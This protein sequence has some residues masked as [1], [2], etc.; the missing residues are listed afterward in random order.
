MPPSHGGS[1]RFEPCTAHHNL[2]ERVNLSNRSITTFLPLAFLI[3]HLLGVFCGPALSAAPGAGAAPTVSGKGTLK[4]LY[5]GA[6]GGELEPCGCSPKTE[7]GGLARLAGYLSKHGAGPE[8]GPYILLDAG[9]AFDKDTPQ[10]RLK[11]GTLLRAFAQM[12]Y[13]AVAIHKENP[14]GPLSGLDSSGFL[15]PLIRKYKLPIVSD[16]PGGKGAVILKQ[17][18][19][20]ATK[21]PFNVNI[22]ADPEG[23]PENLKE[24][25]VNILLTNRP[26]SELRA[27][28]KAD[29]AEA[30][31][32]QWDVVVTSYVEILEEPAREA[33]TLIVSGYPKG[34]KLGILTLRIGEAGK[35]TD[36]NHRWQGLGA[37]V[38]ESP[39]VRAILKEYDARVAELLMAEEEKRMATAESNGPYLGVSTC[40]ECHR[41][42]VESWQ[43][44]L[45]SR[46][47]STLTRAGKSMDPECI[48]CHSTG[49]NEV[50]GFFSIRTTPAL[51][52]VQCEVCHGPGKEHFEDFTSPMTT[53]TEMLC[54]KCHTVDNS[55]EFDFDEY[56]N[57]IKH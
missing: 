13:D 54:L 40:I 1:R 31:K 2:R 44:T 30:G 3:F 56:Y 28:L 23:L 45:H 14:F 16:G 41:P 11:A 38:A 26:L 21:N 12:G 43:E 37:D 17:G 55:P 51:G 5:T 6:L 48:K 19:G 39:E 42:F 53:V 25:H 34:K 4:I 8:A 47:F 57:K 32:P 52:D 22:S 49:Y 24:G 33:G 29:K 27:M 36:F 15:K 9:G 35:V 7:S 46:A 50:G 10:A 18:P 20:G